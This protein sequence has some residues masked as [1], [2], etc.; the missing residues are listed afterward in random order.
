[1]KIVLSGRG[2]R[3][4]IYPLL[5]IASSLTGA[6]HEVQLAIPAEFGEEARKTGLNPFL[7]SEDSRAMM[8]SLGSG[9]RSS[10]GSLAFLTNTLEEQFDFLLEATAGAQVLITHVSEMSA[11]TIAEYRGLRHYRLAYAPILP[12][13]HPPP[14]IPWQNL[15]AFLNRTSWSALQMISRHLL[16]RLLNDKRK[17]LGLAPVTSSVRYYTRHSTA[18]LAY[19]KELS[20]PCPTWDKRGFRYHYT[21][22]CFNHEYGALD[23]QLEAFLREGDP[24]VYVGFGSV[25][26]KDPGRFA[27]IITKAAEDTGTRLVMARGW[28]GLEHGTPSPGI[29]LTD[30]TFHGTL[31]PR[32]AGVI[33]HGGSGTIH[34]AAKAGVP[35]FILPQIVDQFYWGNRVRKMGLGPR[36]VPPKKITEEKMIQVLEAFNN[37]EY[38]SGTQQMAEKIKDEDGVK[39]VVRV[40]EKR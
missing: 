26:L 10:R 4:D 15:P 9:M 16:R 24:P 21:G 33:H 6:G 37:G 34:T 38:A 36:P 12:G 11:P 40:V 18:L 13:N 14:L 28:T 8:K 5:S 20:P 32:M 27:T 23:P 1:M 31:F 19:N 17:A 35:Q 22:Y 39:E 7:Y 30:E 29:F 3:G 25:Q 2:S